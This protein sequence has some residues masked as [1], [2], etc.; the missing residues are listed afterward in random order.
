MTLFKYYILNV[1]SISAILFIKKSLDDII[2]LKSNKLLGYSPPDLLNSP[3][4]LEN[5]FLASKK[6]NRFVKM[7]L[8]E[9]VIALENKEKYCK[10]YDKYA[11]ESLKSRLPYLT[12]H[13][14]FVKLI[15][16]NNL[17]KYYKSIGHSEGKNNPFYLK[18]IY[19]WD[20][21]LFSK[22][23]LNLKLIDE[24]ISF[25]KLTGFYRKAIIKLIN[26]CKFSKDSYLVKLLDIK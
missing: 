17:N 18:K 9:W 6:N 21:K 25:I 19:N 22:K 11:S 12:Q 1:I 10:K 26:K 23:M 24:N 16:T 2:D 3:E 5:W 7:W 4:I 20:D 15:K 8:D 13:L 14:T